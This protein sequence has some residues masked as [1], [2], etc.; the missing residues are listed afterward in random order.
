MADTDLTRL[1]YRGES[2][3]VY[4]DALLRL[5]Q[6]ARDGNDDF[7]FGPLRLTDCE[8]DGLEL[9]GPDLSAPIATLSLVPGLAQVDA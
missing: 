9:S 1:H 5:I 6:L 8:R 2:P 7:T 3:A 4:A